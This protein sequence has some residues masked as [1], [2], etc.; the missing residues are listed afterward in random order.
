MKSFIATSA[1]IAVASIFSDSAVAR[2]DNARTTRGGAE[3]F[4]VGRDRPGHCSH[5]LST[6]P[7]EGIRLYLRR[8]CLQHKE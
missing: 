7:D 3:N 8:D 1:L 5:T 6:D 4:I 2:N